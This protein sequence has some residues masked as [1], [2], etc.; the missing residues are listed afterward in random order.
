MYISCQTTNERFLS[1]L[2]CDQH[3]PTYGYDGSKQITNDPTDLLELQ[4][5]FSREIENEILQMH[6]SKY[7]EN[8]IAADEA[9][10][11]LERIG[12]SFGDGSLV[13]ANE[14]GD[15]ID[16]DMNGIVLISTVTSV[17]P[18]NESGNQVNGSSKPA[19]NSRVKTAEELPKR[20]DSN[21]VLNDN[22]AQD[23]AVIEKPPPDSVT[24]PV[25]T[26]KENRVHDKLN[27]SE[28]QTTDQKQLKEVNGDLNKAKSKNEVSKYKK[29]PVLKSNEKSVKNNKKNS[30]K[31]K[32]MNDPTNTETN[33]EQTVIYL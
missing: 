22:K 32:P 17:E 8:E 28:P 9:A 7:I 3:D 16:R 19:N 29:L 1:M 11:E 5:S 10:T 30:T 4:S 25:K 14:N 26:E 31:V 21:A 27:F 13:G 20:K 23:M 6:N 33:V 18:S 12:G 24:L 2:G 15:V